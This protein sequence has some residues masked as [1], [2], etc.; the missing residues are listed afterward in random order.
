[1]IHVIDDSK[2]QKK[3]FTF[4][5]SLLVKYMKYFEKCLKKISENDEIDISIHC[6]AGIFEWLLNYI[7]NQEELEKSQPNSLNGQ[8]NFT[9][10]NGWQL[11][12]QKC[13]D[14]SIKNNINGSFSN[15]VNFKGPKL[16]QKN[17]V[18]IL[19]SADFLKI[20]R[21]VKHCMEYFV[22]NIEEISKI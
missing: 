8:N 14:D 6:D 19:I 7:F 15:A 20:D 16:D 12:V 1:M 17:V 13:D 3:D 9:T 4:S 21:L 2:N 11:R 5:R 10:T 18:S 22:N